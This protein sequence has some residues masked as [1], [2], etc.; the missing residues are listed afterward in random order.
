MNNYFSPKFSVSEEVRSTAVALI[1]EFNIDRTF[2]LALFLNVNP[3]LNDQDATLAWVNYFEK[4]NMISVTSIMLD[5]T[6]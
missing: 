4:I 6:L 3:N 1:K 2:D 5:A